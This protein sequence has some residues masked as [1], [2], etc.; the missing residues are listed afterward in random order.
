[1]VKEGRN[2]PEIYKEQFVCPYCEV[3]AKQD[4]TNTQ[5]IVETIKYLINHIYLDYRGEVGDY[6]QQEIKKFNTHVFQKLP[7]NLSV[8]FFSQDF[9]FAKCQN[10]SEMSIWMEEDKKMIY[11]R[12]LSFPDPNADMDDDIKE[13]YLEAAKIFQDSPRASAAILRLCVEKLC[14]QLQEKGDLNTCIGNLVERGLDQRIQQALDYCRVI[15]NNA[16]H[17][18]EIDI[19]EDPDMVR[20][21]FDLVNDITRDM[22]TKPKEMEKK[23]SS[24][25]EKVKKQ[26]EKRDKK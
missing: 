25:P 7:R 11:P 23:Y 13:L 24:L 21:L 2:Q 12:L 14:G 16:V 15:G 17:P 19:E 20:F 5:E 8:R 26:I 9:S 10:C 1:M 3:F 6:A 4:W 22:V 18:G